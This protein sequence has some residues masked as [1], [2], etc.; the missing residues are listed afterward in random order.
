MSGRGVRRPEWVGYVQDLWASLPSLRQTA[1]E[2]GLREDQD[3]T[4]IAIRV[5]VDCSSLEL[6]KTRVGLFDPAELPASARSAGFDVA[7]EFLMSALCNGVFFAK[8]NPDTV[9]AQWA[10]HIS[11]YHFFVDRGTA[12][13]FVSVA[14]S[15]FPEHAPFFAFEVLELTPAA[16]PSLD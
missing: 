16:R 6:W 15:R 8:E 12:R 9:R 4:A 7:D 10:P 3:F 1:K 2:A 14:E 5:V 11:A 13:D